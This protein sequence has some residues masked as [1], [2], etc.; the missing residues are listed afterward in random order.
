MQEQYL[1]ADV[2]H[3]GSG[4]KSGDLLHQIWFIP[5]VTLAIIALLYLLGLA[6]ILPRQFVNNIFDYAKALFPF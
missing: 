1:D 6:G 5:A 4:F 2:R 3:G